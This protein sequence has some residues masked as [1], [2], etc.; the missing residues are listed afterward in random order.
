MEMRNSIYGFTIQ[1]NIQW[2]KKSWKKTDPYIRIVSD[3]LEP[4]VSYS[5][6]LTLL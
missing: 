4:E 2:I 1:N 6:E 3:T 5:S